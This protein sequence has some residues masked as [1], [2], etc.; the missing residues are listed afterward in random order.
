MLNLKIRVI[1]GCGLP[2]NMVKLIHTFQYVSNKLSSQ[3]IISTIKKV[4]LKYY[5]RLLRVSYTHKIGNPFLE[6]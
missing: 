3:E 1:L 6:I 5:G 4:M 2:F